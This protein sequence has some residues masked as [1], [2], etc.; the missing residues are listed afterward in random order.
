MIDRDRVAVV[1]SV[2]ASRDDSVVVRAELGDELLVY[3]CPS[4]E[5]PRVRDRIVWRVVENR[6][7]QT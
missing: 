2:T 7:A 4:A 3:R 1:R 5:A 6:G